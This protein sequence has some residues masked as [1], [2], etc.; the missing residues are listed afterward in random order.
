MQKMYRQCGCLYKVEWRLG[1][2]RPPLFCESA[3]LALDQNMH[4]RVSQAGQNQSERRERTAISH[5]RFPSVAVHLVS[6]RGCS[7][8]RTL[9][10]TLKHHEVG[11]DRSVGTAHADLG[12]RLATRG[13]GS[14]S[15]PRARHLL[16]QPL[17]QV[18]H[19]LM[20][21]CRSEIYQLRCISSPRSGKHPPARSHPREPA[22]DE[23]F[24]PT[25][26]FSR[27]RLSPPCLRG[28]RYLCRKRTHRWV[29]HAPA[30]S[31]RHSLSSPIGILS[32]PHPGRARQQEPR[33]CSFCL[34]CSARRRPIR[35][36]QQSVGRTRQEETGRQGPECEM[37]VGAVHP[38]SPTELTSGDPTDEGYR[39][40]YGGYDFLAC[41]TFAKRDTIYSV[42]NQIGTGKESGAWSLC[43]SPPCMRGH[44]EKRA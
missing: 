10:R 20:V 34:D 7:S 22:A 9:L 16:A 19:T 24:S 4:R 35:R 29:A 13:H 28:S 41:R 6:D 30:P 21:E 26:P 32:S 8:L 14:V 18:A 17:D 25:S 43:S 40:T 15:L 42:G 2:V 5:Q 38:V 31:L 44:W 23:N 3:G 11:C 12:S 27:R 39:L 36:C 33:D 37:C 1:T